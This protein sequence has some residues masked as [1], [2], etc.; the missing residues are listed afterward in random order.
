MFITGQLASIQVR[1]EGR[2]FHGV[3]EA[4]MEKGDNILCKA[5]KE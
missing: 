1:K 4:L 5:S 3:Q 2:K